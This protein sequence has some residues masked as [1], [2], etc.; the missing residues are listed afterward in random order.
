MEAIRFHTK[1]VA[2]LNLPG[3][4]PNFADSGEG[5]QTLGHLQSDLAQCSGPCRNHVH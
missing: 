2:S 3:A 5:L 1:N 4:R